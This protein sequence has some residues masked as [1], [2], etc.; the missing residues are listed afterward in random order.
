M[1]IDQIVVG[2]LQSNSYIV[3]DRESGEGLII[4][5]GGDPQKII[6]RVYEKGVKIKGIYATHCHIDHILAIRELREA[7]GCK[8]YIHRADE[9]VLERSVEDA[10]IYL[11]L[12][13]FDPPKPDG[14][15]DDGDEIGIGENVLKVLHTPGHTPG[16]VSYA[17][18]GGVFTGDTLFAGSVGRTDMFGG[19]IRSL[20]RSVIE[21]LFKLPDWYVIYPGHGLTSLIGVEKRFNPYVG[22]DGILKK[23][24]L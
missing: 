11:G 4:D 9:E 18:N 3:F 5:A 10:E 6:H 1:L 2:A 13:S 20:V 7:F 17:F 21:R 8:F 23:F 15:V 14:Y 24:I 12:S 19:D 16:S 22:V